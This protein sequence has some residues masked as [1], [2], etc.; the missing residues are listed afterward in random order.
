MRKEGVMFMFFNDYCFIMLKH[1]VQ[2]MQMLVS[3]FFSKLTIHMRKEGPMV[4][5]FNDYCFIVS[6]VSKEV[7]SKMIKQTRKEGPMV[8]YF[9]NNS[10]IA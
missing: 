5:V 10:F 9:N 1:F 4:V 2:M 6:D 3:K 8:L 7:F